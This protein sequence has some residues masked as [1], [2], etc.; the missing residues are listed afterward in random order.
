M[1]L[2]VFQNKIKLFKNCA[3]LTLRTLERWMHERILLLLFKKLYFLFLKIAPLLIEGKPTSVYTFVEV[4][5]YFDWNCIQN[6]CTNINL[7]KI[8]I[9]CGKRI[10]TQ[11]VKIKYLCLSRSFFILFFPF[12]SFIV[13]ANVIINM[14]T[15]LQRLYSAKNGKNINE[16]MKL[17]N[18]KN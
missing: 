2:L 3:L 10:V 17:S 7:I 5:Q 6:C 11:R 4:K 18:K 8:S 15:Q 16:F 9:L 14:H 12:I 1:A 13:C